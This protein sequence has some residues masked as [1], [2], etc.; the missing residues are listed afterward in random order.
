MAKNK[1]GLCV[2]IAAVIVVVAVIVGVIIA[3]NNKADNGGNGG[4]GTSQ[5]TGLSAADLANVDE[6]I[7]FGDFDAMQTLSKSIQN[8]EKTGKVVKIDGL[9]SKPGTTYS[10]VQENEGGTKKIGTKF[11]IEGAD[12]SAYPKEGDHV[13]IT[14]KVI[15]D[16]N[17]ALSFY[18]ETIAEK[19]E[20][21]E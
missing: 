7:A 21:K 13:V 3:N 4:G 12:T 17:T 18:I 1:T 16:P 14:G 9:V 5:T 8:G 11:V 2:G 6:T 10:I 20:V 15:E 19:V